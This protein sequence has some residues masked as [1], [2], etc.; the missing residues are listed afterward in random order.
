MKTHT[1]RDIVN[2]GEQWAYVKHKVGEFS[3]NFG[4]EIK[5]AKYLIRN[6]LEK[7]I[8]TLA[9]N[10]DE[11]NKERYLDLKSQ[12]NDIIENEIKGSILRGLC[13]DY[14]EGEKCTKYF[15][16][17]EKYKSK[18][19]TLS[20]VKK[21]DGTFTF[22]NEEILEECRAFYKKIVFKEL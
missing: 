22:K 11:N 3:R 19:K 9:K 6:N 7:E 10:L 5:K 1:E 18:Q 17:L 13:K 20:M 14:Q 4:A 2:V 15:F 16:S 12:L 8:E 21:E